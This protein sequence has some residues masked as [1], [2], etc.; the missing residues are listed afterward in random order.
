VCRRDLT[1]QQLSLPGDPQSRPLEGSLLRKQAVSIDERSRD[2]SIDGQGTDLESETVKGIGETREGLVTGASLSDQGQST[3]RTLNLTVG[4]FHTGGLRDIVLEG[5]VDRGSHGPTAGGQRTRRIS[6]ERRP[7]QH[8]RLC[9]KD[10][11]REEEEIKTRIGFVE[12]G[13]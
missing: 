4:E 5:R 1:A 7:R 6:A 13:N 2:D 8:R 10:M 3:G 12:G 9:R 11:Q